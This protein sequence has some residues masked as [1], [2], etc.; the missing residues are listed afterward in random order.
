MYALLRLN[1]S[2]FYTKSMLLPIW[3]GYDFKKLLS[4]NHSI[5]DRP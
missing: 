4:K 2:N 1:G 3:S 5:K